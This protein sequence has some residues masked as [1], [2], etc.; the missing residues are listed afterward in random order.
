MC[1]K[2]REKISMS[3]LKGVTV[4]VGKYLNDFSTICETKID[5]AQSALSIFVNGYFLSPPICSAN[6][7]LRGWYRYFINLQSSS[8]PLNGYLKGMI[9][10]LV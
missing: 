10:A 7:P 8:V 9:H 6:R 1:F 4:H 3:Q 2:E 5:K